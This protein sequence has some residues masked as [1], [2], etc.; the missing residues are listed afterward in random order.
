MMDHRLTYSI[1]FSFKGVEHQP[2]CTL[3]LHQCMS[4]H[5]EL[6]CFYSYLAEVHRI[7]IYSYEHD[8]MTMGEICFESAEGLAT[9]FMQKEHFD[10][11]GFEEAWRVYQRFQKLQTIAREHLAID[12][13]EQH[14]SLALALQ[15]AYQL[16][17]E[18]RFHTPHYI[19]PL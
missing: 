12:D 8:V 15:E 19:P 17:F 13:L 6:P 18:S 2:R 16:G 5:G 10:V 3:D 4:A 9:H 11:D 14:R 7:D 1:S